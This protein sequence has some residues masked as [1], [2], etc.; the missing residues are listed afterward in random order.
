MIESELHTKLAH[1]ER[2]IEVVNDVMHSHLAQQGRGISVEGR[3]CAHVG[4]VELAGVTKV[5]DRHPMGFFSVDK[6]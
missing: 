3:H 2:V 6:Q 1:L 5:R 4:H